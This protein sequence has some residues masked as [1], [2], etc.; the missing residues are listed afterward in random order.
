MLRRY[1]NHSQSKLVFS[2]FFFQILFALILPVF[3]L[4]G[5]SSNAEKSNA[6]GNS[7]QLT[8]GPKLS[9]DTDT[10]D[11]GEIN[12]SRVKKGV[13]VISNVGDKTLVID[14]ISLFILQHRT[15]G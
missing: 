7:E 4:Q 8:S 5:C 2:G 14:D 10:Y 6:A 11:F 1:I 13:F 12:P 9:V 15:C 3:I